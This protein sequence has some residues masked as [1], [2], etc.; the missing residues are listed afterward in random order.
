MA[1]TP[2]QEVWG[3]GRRIAHKLAGQGITT[4]EQLAAT[5][6]KWLRRR[7]S[8]ALERTVRELQ[9]AEAVCPGSHLVY[10]YR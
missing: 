1:I 7:F 4:A 5:D 2:V 6:L 9:G 3:V 8:V 10:S